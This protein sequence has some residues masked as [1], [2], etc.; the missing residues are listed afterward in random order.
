MPFP[1]QHL[2]LTL[3]WTNSGVTNETG[4]TGVRINSPNNATQV[5]AD[6]V[7]GPCLACW[8]SVGMG[9][10]AQFVLKYIRLAT[11]GTDGKY[12]P[13]SVAY[14]TVFTGSNAGTGTGSPLWPMQTAMAST[15][16]TNVPRGQAAKGRMFFPPPGATL[17]GGYRWS[18]AVADARSSAV[19]A[20]LQALKVPLGGPVS[21][22]S[23]GTIQNPAGL[24]HQATGVTSGR[25]PDVQRR[26]GKGVQEL[27]GAVSVLT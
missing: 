21:V 25:R 23:R 26:R 11:I 16:V 27:Y 12:V 24:S 5:L 18:A 1:N 3:H 19:A 15:L 13:G 4:Q 20:L 2:Y 22:F 9:V 8:R 17:D 14:D 10:D 7:S 6:S